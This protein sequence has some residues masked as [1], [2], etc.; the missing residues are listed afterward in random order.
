M[1]QN[2]DEHLDYWENQWA[3]AAKTETDEQWLRVFA[4]KDVWFEQ[5]FAHILPKRRLGNKVLDFGC[6]TSMYSVPLLR[7]FD[8]YY[9]A[10]PSEN[11]IKLANRYF[12][13]QSN[14]QVFHTIEGNRL[15]FA[16]G[17]FDCVVSI[18]VLQHMSVPDRLVAIAEIKRVLKPGGC[19]VGLEW[20]QTKMSIEAWRQAWQPIELI[21]DLSPEHPEWAS[22]NVWYSKSC[23]ALEVPT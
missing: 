12:R 3:T 6:G 5:R 8:R 15:P 7:R 23:I 19:Y 16:D 13:H 22:D 9:G 10:D 1:T 2:S 11:A 4:E 14:W 20:I 17:F 18:T 21:F